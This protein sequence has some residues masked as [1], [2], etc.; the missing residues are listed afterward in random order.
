MQFKDCMLFPVWLKRNELQGAGMCSGLGWAWQQCLG[1]EVGP[2]I[3]I[4]TQSHTPSQP[5]ATHRYVYCQRCDKN[6]HDS[7]YTQ[8]MYNTQVI[9]FF[10]ISC[11]AYVSACVREPRRVAVCLHSTAA[12]AE[13]T[14]IQEGTRK[15]WVG[16][17]IASMAL[18]I[19]DPLASSGAALVHVFMYY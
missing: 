8:Y 16:H 17:V 9:V 3:S 2:P 13:T 18:S 15:S 4:N 5:F 12:V 11:A 6:S 19:T 7:R 10:R 14:R 1:S